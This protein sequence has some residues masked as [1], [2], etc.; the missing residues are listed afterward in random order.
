[1]CI[2]DRY[3]RRVH[4]HSQR[5]NSKQ[6][7]F[8]QLQ[9]LQ[10]Q[11]QHQQQQPYQHSQQ[12]QQ[13]RYPGKKPSLSQVSQ[14]KN[15]QAFDFKPSSISNFDNDELQQSPRSRN[16][17]SAFA[18]IRNLPQ[19][20]MQ[21][22]SIFTSNQSRE[23]LQFQQ[24]P[25]ELE[26]VGSSQKV[27]QNN[28]KKQILGK[29]LPNFQLNRSAI[30]NKT[31]QSQK[32]N[33]FEGQQDA[34]MSNRQ[35]DGRT[36]QLSPS[37]PKLNQSFDYDAIVGQTEFTESLEFFGDLPFIDRKKEF[38][39]YFPSQNA[40]IIL[41]K[42]L[43]W[44]R[45]KNSQTKVIFKS[46]QYRM[47]T[48]FRNMKYNS[49]LNQKNS[50]QIRDSIDMIDEA[51]IISPSNN[52]ESGNFSSREFIG[53]NSERNPLKQSDQDEKASEHQ[54]L[55]NESLKRVSNIQLSNRNQAQSITLDNKQETKQN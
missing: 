33:H 2:R 20:N 11:N 43:K 49:S 39:I 29:Q 46:K 22:K 15:S 52:R 9:P 51:Q 42:Y 17:N 27:I 47:Q 38:K 24:I 34:A 37:S 41:L 16:E 10:N 36:K 54:L 3:Q 7:N 35:S 53:L 40:N 19:Y 14:K 26:Y 12:Q 1:M 55:I 18:N 8:K 28:D 13:E 32:S 48:R 30:Q 6:F 44:K 25:R 5:Y 31:L 4:G 50:D 23:L 45:R 21:R